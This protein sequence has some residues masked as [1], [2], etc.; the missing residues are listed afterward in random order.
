MNQVLPFRSGCRQERGGIDFG[1]NSLVRV[2]EVAA[3]GAVRGVAGI[4]VS[5]CQF[6]MNEFRIHSKP[7]RHR[8][9]EVGKNDANAIPAAPRKPLVSAIP[10]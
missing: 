8:I 5:K 2:G 10:R 4:L 9:G 1:G 6:A 7:H 3:T